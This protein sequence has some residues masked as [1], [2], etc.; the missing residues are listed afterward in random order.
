M[1]KMHKW[2]EKLTCIFIKWILLCSSKPN[3]LIAS[4][5]KMKLI[6]FYRWCGPIFSSF[7][8]MQS[9]FCSFKFMFGNAI[10]SK[11]L[12]QG[13]QRKGKN[14]FQCAYKE[15]QQNRLVRQPCTASA[16]NVAV[17]A[18]AGEILQKQ[19]RCV[20]HQQKLVKTSETMFRIYQN[21][22]DIKVCLRI[23]HSG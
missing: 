4:T 8:C 19:L 6:Y 9:Y 3:E 15:K 14:K 22:W 2:L 1:A 21:M 10:N 20:C 7:S 13:G 5:T 23:L 18:P 17:G 11:M 12:L 16:R